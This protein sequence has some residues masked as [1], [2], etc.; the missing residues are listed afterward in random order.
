[1]RGGYEATPF[2][3]ARNKQGSSRGATGP[4]DQSR[5]TSRESGSRPSAWHPHL[6][7]PAAR[8]AGI[9]VPAALA[10]GVRLS[11][12]K[13]DPVGRRVRR[14]EYKHRLAEHK[15]L[16]NRTPLA[17][18]GAMGAVVA[19]TQVVAGLNIEDVRQRLV[20]GMPLTPGVVDIAIQFDMA[21]GGDRP[22]RSDAGGC[23]DVVGLCPPFLLSVLRFVFI[24]FGRAVIALSPKVDPLAIHPDPQSTVHVG[25]AELVGARIHLARSR[26]CSELWSFGSAAT[27]LHSTVAELCLESVHAFREFENDFRLAGDFDFTFQNQIANPEMLRGSGLSTRVVAEE[28][29]DVRRLL[30]GQRLRIGARSGVEVIGGGRLPLHGQMAIAN[31]VE[32]T[33]GVAVGAGLLGGVASP[34]GGTRLRRVPA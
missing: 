4:C 31:P 10:A 32:R 13:P 6:R 1:M 26:P 22:L 27:Q 12:D 28:V 25:E 3:L 14:P 18:V 24:R 23:V 29:L 21:D 11:L 7:T 20:T 5:R 33:A 16:R 34:V 15:S 9:L 2:G 17:A 8:A 19:Q 30:C